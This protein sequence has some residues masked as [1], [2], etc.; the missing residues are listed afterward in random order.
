AR[1]LLEG[2]KLPA[3]EAVRGEEFVNPFDQGYPKPRD[4]AFGI[5]ADGARA[6]FHDGG[7]AI[8]RF[9]VQG[10]DVP[11]A[12]RK[13]ASLTFI[14]DVSGS[15]REGGRLEM[16]KTALSMLVERLHADDTV[17]IVVFTSNAWVALNPTNG[18]NKRD[19]LNAIYSLTPQNTTNADA[20]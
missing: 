12:E 15:M 14:I 8:L 4:V 13:P 2:G 16:V 7:T 9:G 20:G 18:T 11:D 6:P 3:Q 5:Y 10:Y 1:R 17:G 19:I